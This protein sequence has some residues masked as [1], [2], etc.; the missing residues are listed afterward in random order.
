[1]NASMT[2]HERFARMYAH[3]EADRVPIVDIP[4][5]STLERWHSEG[6]PE[7]MPFED[8][9]DIDRVITIGVDNSPRYETKIVEDTPQYTI[10]TSAW[11]VTMKQW[12]HMA[13]TPE[14]MSFTITDPASWKT[15]KARMAPSRDRIPWDTLKANYAAWRQAG[16]WIRG[17]L[18]FGFDVSH[19]WMVG[20]ERFLMAL[21]EEPEW[22]MDM[23][24]TQ[25][26]LDL[27]LLDMVWEA[28]YTFDEI[29]WPD[30]MGYNLNQFFS[31]QTY[32]DLLKPFHRRAIE[33]AHARGI[34]AHL[35]SCGD[36]RPFIPEL[37]SIGLDALNPLEVKAGI[38]PLTVKE[39][40]GCD[41]VLI[42]GIN[43]VL[44]DKPDA[45][46]DEMRRLVPRMKQD[47]GYVFSSDH[48]VPSSVS[49]EDFRRI[50]ALAKELGRY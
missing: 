41:L 50:T 13:S 25:L 42:G 20:T 3:R 6:L 26:T 14:F 29:S 34:K 10:H 7:G 8:F 17:G 36:I 35:H 38:N 46:R 33:W 5:K 45:I 24:D 44:W 19:S 2:S 30:D 18:W 40:Y 15:T 9:F 32:R 1:M 21:V 49:L 22:C 39:T 37:I 12:K 47:G 48:S 31:I 11:G 28:G 16:R 23:F 27:Q 43:A 4:W